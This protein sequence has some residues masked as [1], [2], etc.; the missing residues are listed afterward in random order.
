MTQLERAAKLHEQGLLSDQ[1]F[2]D[3]KQRLL[4]GKVA[5]PRP[6]ALEQ[7]TQPEP[8]TS[9][10]SHRGGSDKRIPALLL[11]G[12][13]AFQAAGLRRPVRNGP[14]TTQGIGAPFA[15]SRP[16]T[17]AGRFGGLVKEAN[18][19]PEIGAGGGGGKSGA[20]QS[21]S[22]GTM[23]MLAGVDPVPKQQPG[24][25]DLPDV[26]DIVNQGTP[27]PGQS[28]TLPSGTGV[29][30]NPGGTSTQWSPPGGQPFTTETTP[31]RPK[32]QST[33]SPSQQSSIT[34][35]QLTGVEPMPT[36]QQG[37]MDLID[38]LALTKQG[39]IKP[40]TTTELPSGYT[41]ENTTTTTEN[42]VTVSTNTYSYPGAETTS[43]T[44]YTRTFNEPFNGEGSSYDA[45]VDENGN[46]ISV[47]VH[48]S[49][50]IKQITFNPDHSYTVTGT[51]GSTQRFDPTGKPITKPPTDLDNPKSQATKDWLREGWHTA[52]SLNRFI[53]NLQGARGV[54][55][56]KD[57]AETLG[58]AATAYGEWALK[59]QNNPSANAE[60]LAKFGQ[61]LFRYDELVQYGPQYWQQ[62]MGLDIATAL[63]G[64]EGAGAARPLLRAGDEAAEGLGAGATAPKGGA[65]LPGTVDPY[66]MKLDIDGPRALE[67]PGP[68]NNLGLN[69]GELSWSRTAEGHFGDYGKGLDPYPSRPYMRSNEFT[70][71]IID[72]VPP[73]PDPQGYPGA[74]LWEAPGSLRGTPGTYELVIDVPNQTIIH[75]LFKGDR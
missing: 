73:V 48:G 7:P 29:Q 19:K 49:K 34:P 23:G 68:S 54:D 16:A 57:G 2:A 67:R 22:M 12:L 30:T 56:F 28:R 6:P 32:Q 17:A 11:A 18:S 33:P 66:G 1:E 26:I 31:P 46:L 21:S 64:G 69:A 37:P 10:D 36:Q 61:K 3:L 60:L 70:Q 52:T 44:E 51:D 75:Y 25:G 63:I 38:V 53:Q 40:N 42:G 15:R 27:E 59:N 14:A 72:A 55:G 45:T 43:R 24:V 13:T 62:K 74:M 35:Q 50:T 71:M 39:P 65:A 8:T 5:P 58:N 9:T 4:N 41:I 20:G 47:T